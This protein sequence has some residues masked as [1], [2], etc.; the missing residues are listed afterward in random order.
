MLA[1]EHGLNLSGKTVLKLMRQENRQSK[2][3]QKKYRSFKGEVGLAAPNLLNRDFSATR[4]NQKWATDVTEFKVL[5][6]KQYF[7]P[8]IDLFNGEVISFELSASPAMP[9][10]SKMLDKAVL[11][12]PKGQSPILHSDQGW[13]YRHWQY[14][15]TLKRFGITQSMSRKGNCL[16]NAVAENFFGHF[17]EEFLRQRQFK[18][19]TEF[20]AELDHY[21]HWFN[22]ERIQLRLKGLSPVDYRTQSLASVS[23]DS[24]LNLQ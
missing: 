17:K 1:S 12:L 9:L 6:Q 13:Q 19:L 11:Q 24:Y 23:P 22:H 10:I 18:S 4:P 8:V 21:I 5:G 16:D 14:Q 3:R 20:K 2:V 15:K 7:S